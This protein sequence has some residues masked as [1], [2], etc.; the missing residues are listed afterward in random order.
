MNSILQGSIYHQ[1]LTPVEHGFTYPFFFLALDL[2]HMPSTRLFGYGRRRLLSI[3]DS[4]YLDAAPEPLAVKAR[5]FLGQPVERVILCTAPR[6]AGYVFNPVSFYLGYDSANRIT[7]ALAEVN[8]TF[9]ERHVYILQHP[10]TGPD[11]TVRFTT[12]K[13]FHVSPFNDRLGEYQFRLNADAGQ[14][15]IHVDIA[16]E[17][18]IVFKSGMAGRVSGAIT[19]RLLLRALLRY[20]WQHLLTL[21]RIHWQAAKLY[22]GKKLRYYPKPAPASTMTITMSPPTLIEK[23]GQTIFNRLFRRVTHGQ[24]VMTMPDGSSRTYGTPAPDADAVLQVKDHTFFRRIL[25]NGDIGLGEAYMYGQWDSPDVTGFLSY[26]IRNRDELKNGE[27]ITSKISWLANRLTHLRRP[28]TKRNSPRNISAH[29]DL[30]NEFFALFLDP[31]MMYSSA[32]FTSPSDTLEQAQRH[33][34]SVLIDKLDLSPEHHVL[35]IGSGWGGFAIEMARQR[36]CRVTSITVSREQLEL[37]RQRVRDAGLE[38]RVSI[39]FCDYRDAAGAY[40]RVVSIEM[41]EAVGHEHFDDYFASIHRVLKPGGR[42]V[43]QV[44]TIAHER[45][46]AYRRSVDWIQKYIFPGGLIPSVQIL[47][48]SMARVSPHFT[49]A[50]LEDIGPH[51]ATTLRRWSENLAAVRDRLTSMGYDDVF[52]RT[53]QYYFSYCEAGFITKALADMHIVVERK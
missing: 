34:M 2:D 42:V 44:I 22:F 5:R 45:Y 46:D 27:F 35:E 15:A 23:T 17:G 8:N 25:L 11:G 4:D 29:Y 38:D 20:P 10:V 6:I 33:R 43:L 1:R 40:D 24:L 50:D 36:G 3:R 32:I 19:D 30:S 41:L 47:K 48:E 28:N 37:A 26:L 53:W 18:R 52:Y 16:R 12:Q 39:E 14:I 51:Y 21:P 9:G 13:A 7:G 49:I 31:T